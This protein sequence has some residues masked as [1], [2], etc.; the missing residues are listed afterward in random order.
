[1]LVAVIPKLWQIPLH[2]LRELGPQD[3]EGFVMK[4]KVTRL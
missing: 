2:T 1:M 4:L 3:N